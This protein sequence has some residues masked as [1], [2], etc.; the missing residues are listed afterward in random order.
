MLNL[1]WIVNNQ[2]LP[3]KF[4]EKMMVKLP[5][6]VSII[7]PSAAMW[8]IE[9]TKTNEVELGGDGWKEF[10]KTYDLHENNLLMFKYNQ[11]LSFEVLIFD[12]ESFCEKEASYFVK[13][14]NHKKAVL[15][16]AKKRTIT[17]AFSMEVVEDEDS[18]D[19]DHH[20]P[21]FV[22]SKNSKNSIA[23]GLRRNNPRTPRK[24]ALT[25]TP[26]GGSRPKKMMAVPCESPSKSKAPCGERPVMYFL[27]EIKICILKALES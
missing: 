9:L 10:V 26:G 18:D 20:D 27:L 22:V 6:K 13:Q 12:Q 24:A 2:V 17:E 7:G 19:E 11:N 21:E 5:N 15:E 25:R 16:N 8:D 23:E 3:A 1:I 14:C 4:A